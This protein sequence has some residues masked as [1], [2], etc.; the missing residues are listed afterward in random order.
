M[1]SFEMACWVALLVVLVG[2]LGYMARDMRKG[3]K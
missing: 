3:K 2:T 1:D